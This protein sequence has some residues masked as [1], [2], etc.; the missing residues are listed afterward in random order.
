MSD[1]GCCQDGRRPMGVC[2]LQAHVNPL[3]GVDAGDQE[4]VVRLEHGLGHPPGQELL[5]VSTRGRELAHVQMSSVARQMKRV[6]KV[7]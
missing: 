6:M 3:L 1:G 7:F 4:L 2:R 5:V